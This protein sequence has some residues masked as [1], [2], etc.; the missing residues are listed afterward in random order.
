MKIIIL[1]RDKV[2]DM[3]L[4]TPMLQHLRGCL[5][6]ARIHLLAN[7]YNAWVMEEIGRASCRERV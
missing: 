6:Q 3:L 4:V 1:K 5:P 2:G 7:D